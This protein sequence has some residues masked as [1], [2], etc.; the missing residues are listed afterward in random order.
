MFLRYMQSVSHDFLYDL[1]IS[2]SVI[3]CTVNVYPEESSFGMR[4]HVQSLLLNIS[5]LLDES[6]FIS[7][8]MTGRER[9]GLR[10][11]EAERVT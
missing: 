7:V 6:Y 11:A 4:I 2:L 1:I 10:K 9:I 8:R 3:S 5:T